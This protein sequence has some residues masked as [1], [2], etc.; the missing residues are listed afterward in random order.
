G[1]APPAP[2][3]VPAPSTG[4]A[5][6]RWLG[7]QHAHVDVDTASPGIVLVRNVAERHWHATVDGRPVP[8]LAADS[9]I[10]GVAVPAGHHVVDVRYDDPPI[11]IGLAGSS[12]AVAGL[13]LAAVLLRRRAVPGPEIKPSR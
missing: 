5:R 9:L 11:G 2:P 8:I 13:V 4:S 6:F 7:P 10:Q 12:L 3:A 1:L